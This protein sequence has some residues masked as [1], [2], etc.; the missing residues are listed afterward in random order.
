MV[1]G[2]GLTSDLKWSSENTFFSVIPYTFQSSK[3][4]SG[5]GGGGLQPSTSAGPET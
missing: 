1:V 4:G 5:E 3:G 2:G